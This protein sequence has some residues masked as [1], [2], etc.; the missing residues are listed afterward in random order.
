VCASVCVLNDKIE[1]ISISR[2]MWA[3]SG[4]S[5]S[6][7]RASRFYLFLLNYIFTP[8]SGGEL[9]RGRSLLAG[10]PESRPRLHPLP[11][12]GQGLH[13]GARLLHD[14][15]LDPGGRGCAAPRC[16]GPR[17]WVRSFSALGPFSPFYRATFLLV[18]LGN[19]R[20]IFTHGGTRLRR[21]TWA[22]MAVAGPA[23]WYVSFPRSDLSANWFGNLRGRNWAPPKSSIFRENLT[24]TLY[25]I[26]NIVLNSRPNLHIYHLA[27][28]TVDYIILDA[29]D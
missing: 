14:R 29:R 28:P 24:T 3:A 7:R 12:R 16:G 19:L 21:A 25:L 6:T 26:S 15:A 11:A 17:Q 5:T 10:P 8:A 18:L 9:W 23:N 2:C 13:G 20:G 27:N 1:Y 4:R 22:G